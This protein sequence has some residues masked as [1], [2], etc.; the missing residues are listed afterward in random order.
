VTAPIVAYPPPLWKKQNIILYHGTIE[1]SAKAIAMHGVNVRLGRTHTDFGPGFYTTTLRRQA[2]MWAFQTAALRALPAAVLR[3]VV[4]RKALAG[5]ETLAFVR[6]DFN[7]RDFWSFVHHC[8]RGAP[9]HNRF[10]TAK[11][12]DVVYGPVAAFWGQRAIVY[13]ADQISFHTAAAA[14]CLKRRN[15]S[16]SKVP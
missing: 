12:Y 8:R 9:H 13:G 15:M 1:A 10:G 11:F 2:V 6:G 16:W 5:V 14:K 7:A 3:I 4:S